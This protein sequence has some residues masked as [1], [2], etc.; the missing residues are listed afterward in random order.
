MLHV[1]SHPDLVVPRAIRTLED[2]FDPHKL[3]ACLEASVSGIA[4]FIIPLLA[5]GHVTNLVWLKPP[6][7]KQIRC[8]T[9]EFHVGFY[10]S[11]RASKG[12]Q[13]EDGLR[14]TTKLPYF[15]DDG[16]YAPE[17][18]LVEKQPVSL[19]VTESGD[20]LVPER[21]RADFILDIC[22][23][24]FSVNNP[25]KVELEKTYGTRISELATYLFLEAPFYRLV[26]SIRVEGGS[27]DQH[28]CLLEELRSSTIMKDVEAITDIDEEKLYALQVNAEQEFKA[29][30]LRY[31]RV[32]RCRDT[33]SFYFKALKQRLGGCFLKREQTTLWSRLV[34][35][36]ECISM[37]NPQREQQS[38]REVYELGLELDRTY[39]LSDL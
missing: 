6:W 11:Q 8:G 1:D 23:D 35:L 39:S 5:A 4:E 34:E 9:E 32:F 14:V 21:F 22:L 24:Y 17:H 16:S 7:A 26:E 3:Y 37:M 36:E 13:Q 38:V 30:L 27:V 19:V 15:R 2:L 12:D 18:C 25:F 31:L 28:Q 33:D 20:C 29:M 10:C